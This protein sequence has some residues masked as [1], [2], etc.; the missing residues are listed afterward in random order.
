MF[1][2]HCCCWITYTCTH[3]MSLSLSDTC[4]LIIPQYSLL[5]L[6]TPIKYEWVSPPSS[7]LTWLSWAPV[8]PIISFYDVKLPSIRS[9]LICSLTGHPVWRCCVPSAVAAG[10]DAALS[11]LLIKA[12]IRPNPGLQMSSL[13]S[14]V[15]QAA[16]EDEFFLMHPLT[17]SVSIYILMG[18]CVLYEI[19]DVMSNGWSAIPT[20]S[21]WLQRISYSW[22]FL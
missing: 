8:S 20:K 14:Q 21:M 18:C 12:V 10:R 3:T 17:G 13:V 1:Y 6:K 19:F 15:C 5:P 22:P 7:V 16:V 11:N 2:V 4:F 9:H